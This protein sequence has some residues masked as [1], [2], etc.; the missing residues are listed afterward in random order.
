MRDR[1]G[2]DRAARPAPV[3]PVGE[4]SVSYCAGEYTTVT[5]S[6]SPVVQS[7]P[8]DAP[9][10][11][12]RV[13]LMS[14]MTTL[15]DFRVTLSTSR[16]TCVAVLRHSI[17]CHLPSAT[18]PAGPP[19]MSM[20]L[21]LPANPQSTMPL[22]RTSMLVRGPGDAPC[23]QRSQSDGACRGQP[24]FLKYILILTFWLPGRSEDTF[25]TTTLALMP[26][27]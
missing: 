12:S 8:L 21:L 4:S 7:E 14:P 23:F 26:L 18:P 15:L 27:K 9:I 2:Q 6:S 17:L 19:T 5:S 10:V 11:A 13:G 24:R 20:W 22:W 1:P 16:L 25:G 3:Q